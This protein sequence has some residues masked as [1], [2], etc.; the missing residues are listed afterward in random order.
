MSERREEMANQHTVK[1]ERESLQALSA[2]EWEVSRQRR[3]DGYAAVLTHLN[4]AMSAL[5]T[6]DTSAVHSSFV[7]A[8]THQIHNARGRLRAVLDK[9]NPFVGG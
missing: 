7:D 4:A 5:P 1:A 8:I 6:S 3:V 2:A 9:P